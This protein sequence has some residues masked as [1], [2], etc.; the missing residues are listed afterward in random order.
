[1]NGLRYNGSR[2][3]KDDD[4]IAVTFFGSM[5]LISSP[6]IAILLRLNSCA[7][8]AF[9]SDVQEKYCISSLSLQS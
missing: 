9:S 7:T 5:F 2:G 3:L 8:A 1:M 4:D 6:E